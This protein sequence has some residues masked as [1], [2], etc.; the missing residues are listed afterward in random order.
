MYFINME[1]T[2][3]AACLWVERVGDVVLDPDR[4]LESAQALLTIL[5]PGLLQP[6]YTSTYGG[7]R[8]KSPSGQ[9]S[10]RTVTPENEDCGA[11]IR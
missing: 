4:T 1:D 7:G 10:L 11:V 2:K 5:M 6:S 3:A 8:F 9:T